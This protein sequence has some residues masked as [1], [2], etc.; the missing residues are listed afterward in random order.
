[1]R[2]LLAAVML[3]GLAAAPAVAQQRPVVVELFT[4]QGCSSCPPAD[5]LLIELAKRPDVLALGYHVT[6]WNSL[7]W[8]DPFSLEA[9]TQRQYAYQR[10]LGSETVYTPQMIVD[11]RTDVVGSDR[12]GVVHAIAGAHPVQ[13]VSVSV[14]AR[15]AGLQV[16]VGAGGGAARVLL[17]GYDGIHNT[18]VA[19]GENAGRQLSEANIVRSSTVLADWTGSALTLASPTPVGEHVAVLL[20]DRDGH[21]LGAATLGKPTGASG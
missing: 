12:S 9:A 2:P 11:G 6:Y 1:M 10:L 4:S 5:A 8:R 15:P 13:S 16:A 19:R 3:S 18:S 14:T 7:G 17:I 20:Q 21:I